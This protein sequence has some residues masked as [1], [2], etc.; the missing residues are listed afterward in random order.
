M[1]TFSCVLVGSGMYPIRF[2]NQ[3]KRNSVPMNGN[4]FFAIASSMFPRVMLSRIP[5]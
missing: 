4:H 1:S 5:V 2:E 3:M